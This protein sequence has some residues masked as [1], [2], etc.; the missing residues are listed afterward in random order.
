VTAAA[1]ARVI[2]KYVPEVAMRLPVGLDR[3]RVEGYVRELDLL[4]ALRREVSRDQANDVSGRL[5]V[6]L[7]QR[8]PLQLNSHPG[9]QLDGP[10]QAV[11]EQ[12]N[13][14]EGVLGKVVPH[15]LLPQVAL[16]VHTQSQ[17]F[18][19]RLL[20]KAAVGVAHVAGRYAVRR[21]RIE[22]R[23]FGAHVLQSYRNAVAALLRGA[24]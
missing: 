1:V 24:S 2:A 7:E 4:D 22:R 14:I 18:Q 9:R 8:V 21:G 16:T 23:R 17:Q 11:Q 3:S 6:R 12:L 5:D 15:D 10:D 19:S 13:R 20:T